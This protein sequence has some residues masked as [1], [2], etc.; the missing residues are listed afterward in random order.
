MTNVGILA[1]C[2]GLG[3]D[4]ELLA[5]SLLLPEAVPAGDLGDDGGINKLAVPTLNVCGPNSDDKE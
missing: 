2:S 3:D 1:V 5:T 4:L